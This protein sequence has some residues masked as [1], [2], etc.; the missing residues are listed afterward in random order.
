MNL[1]RFAVERKTLTN[2]IV[3]LLV[4]GGLYSYSELGR[5]VD[6]RATDCLGMGRGTQQA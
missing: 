4:A 2:F 6:D 1:T 5:L 3:F